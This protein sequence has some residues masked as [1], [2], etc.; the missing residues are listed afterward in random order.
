MHG[1]FRL[2]VCLATSI[3][4]GAA[5]HAADYPAKPV[6]II[7][8][9]A[10]GSA[11]DLLIRPIAQKLAEHLGS[12]FVIDNRP[13]AGANIGAEIAAKAAPDGYTLFMVSAPHAVAPSLYPKLAYDLL[14]DFAP[15]T[16]IGT[17]QLCLAVHPS[18]PA[19]TIKDFVIF[20]KSHPD[21]VS[22]GS[23]GNGAVNHLAMELFKS[24]SGIRLIHVPYKGTAFA[25][26]DVINGR[27]PVLF[28]N[29]APLLPHLRSGRLRPLGVTAMRRSPAL[30]DV[31]TVA[32]S[33]YPEFQATNWYGVLAPAGVPEDIIR[34]MNAALI[35]AVTAPNVREHY[36]NNGVESTT[37]TPEAMRSFLR[38]EIEKWARIVRISSARVD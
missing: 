15:V 26:P 22:Y 12:Q 21:A 37:S 29:L 25:L 7:V 9:Q 30:P 1:S 5:A 18:L 35:E 28:G 10:P 14:R 13:G 31:P 27:V 19:K 34:K 16:M 4:A 33:G 2:T 24:M 6:R 8:A 32:E 11:S 38:G 36:A 20:L 3:V 23:S 17:E